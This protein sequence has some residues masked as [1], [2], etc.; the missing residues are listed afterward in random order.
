MIVWGGTRPLWDCG[1]IVAESSV[2][3]LVD[4]DA[5]ESGRLFVW[6]RLELGLDLDDERRSHGGKQTGL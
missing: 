5:E 4:E 3:D 6:V 2:V 1:D